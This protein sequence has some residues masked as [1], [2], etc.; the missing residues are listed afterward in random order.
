VNPAPSRRGWV[1]HQ[2]ACR[3]ATPGDPGRGTGRPGALEIDWAEALTASLGAG[4]QLT[5]SEHGAPQLLHPSG[6]WLSRSHADGLDL[7]LLSRRGPVGIDVEARGRPLSAGVLQRLLGPAEADWADPTRPELALLAW[8]AKEAITKALGRGIGYGLRRL[9][10]GTPP[11]ARL[12]LV[13]IRLVA[14]D[15]P[16]AQW[17]WRIVGQLGSDRIVVAAEAHRLETALDAPTSSV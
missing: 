12:G 14:A 7:L 16:A 4:W 6:A 15:G 1:L 8:C 9:V 5:R 10:L 2:A 3:P 17:R 13:R 11:T